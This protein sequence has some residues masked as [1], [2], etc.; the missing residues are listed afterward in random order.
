MTEKEID[1]IEAP[2]KCLDAALGCS[3]FLRSQSTIFR[4]G[5]HTATLST[6]DVRRG[7]HAAMP[8]V[9]KTAAKL[10]AIVVRK[11]PGHRAV[12]CRARC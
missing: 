2:S 10:H 9:R 7:R 8:K 6:K 1:R 11:R 3:I 4:A 12:A 5:V